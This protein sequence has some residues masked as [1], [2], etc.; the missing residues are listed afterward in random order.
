MPRNRVL[1][2]LTAGLLLAACGTA[3]SPSVPSASTGIRQVQITMTDALRFEPGQIQARTGETLE[4]VVRN[5]GNIRHELFL[6][7]ETEQ[8][9]HEAEMRRMTMAQDEPNGIF[10]EPGQTKVLRHTFGAAGTLIAGCHE[11]GHYP[12]GMKALISV[13]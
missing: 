4:L 10:V 8:A 2:I 3:G 11:V 12:A 9:A 5:A 13:N 1:P 6:G 7:S